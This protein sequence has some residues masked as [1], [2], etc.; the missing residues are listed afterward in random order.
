VTLP[1]LEFY[2]KQ[3]EDARDEDARSRVLSLVLLDVLKD[4]GLAM[5]SHKFLYEWLGVSPS[6][7]RRVLKAMVSASGAQPCHV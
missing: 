3:M 2:W 5:Y 6:T 1:I 4:Q 7:I